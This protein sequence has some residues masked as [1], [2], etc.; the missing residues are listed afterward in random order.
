MVETRFRYGRLCVGKMLLE[1]PG[2]R[3]KTVGPS[4][5]PPMTSAMTLGWRILAN[6]MARTLV[7]MRMSESWMMK[8]VMGFV[9]S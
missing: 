4:K 2:M 7:K 1:K 6:P 3:P 8:S 9:G 5:M